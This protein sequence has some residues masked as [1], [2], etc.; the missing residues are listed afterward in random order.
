MPTLAEK[1]HAL[2]TRSKMAQVHN[3]SGRYFLV[4]GCAPG[5]LGFATARQLLEQGANVSITTRKDSVHLRGDLL[6]KLSDDHAARLHTFDM[7]LA[8]H[9]SVETFVSAY[10]Y[11]GMPLHVLI[12]NAG[13]HLDLMSKWSEPKLS[14]DKEEIQWRVNYLGTTHL[15]MRLLPLLKKT[16][17]SCKDVRVVNVVS[18]LHSKGR[19]ADFFAQT[20]PYN[21]WNAYGQSKLGLVHFTRTLAARYGDNGI[22]S[23]CLHPGSVY[24]NVASKG[25]SGTGWVEKIRNA[26]APLE[27]LFLKTAKEGAQ[28]QIHCATAN[29][30]QLNSGQ[31]YRNL[32]QAKASTEANDSSVADKLWLQMERRLKT[33]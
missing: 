5:S 26:A 29:L 31:Y 4:T 1:L 7:D 27:K 11:T 18:M 17:Q 22:S 15:T 21:S 9:D 12:N 24:T 10:Q 25:L 23:Y 6:H 3:L 33:L 16:A 2:I 14:A 28:T 19:N 30:A 8:N 20:R 32:Q 13:I